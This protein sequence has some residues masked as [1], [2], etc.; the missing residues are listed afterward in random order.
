MKLTNGKILWIL[1]PSHNYKP[2]K[3]R[4]L[5]NN[6]PYFFKIGDII[7][8]KNNTNGRH[9]TFYYCV[10]HALLFK[11]IEK[12]DIKKLLKEN[13]INVKET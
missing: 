5:H 8:S 10:K 2:R 1:T 12:K 11:I 6:K 7:L 3:C 9:K 4:E 13:K